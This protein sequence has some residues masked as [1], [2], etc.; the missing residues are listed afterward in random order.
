MERDTARL[1]E[2]QFST[3]EAALP[4]DAFAA[5]I[6]LGGI[7]M[8]IMELDEH[9]T[10]DGKTGLPNYRALKERDEAQQLHVEQDAEAVAS[11]ERRADAPKP[12]VGW[13]VTY[14][15]LD[16]FKLVNDVLG[17]PV[18]DRALWVLAT[19][20]TKS[21]RDEDEVYR[22]G[23]DEFIVFAPVTE[24]PPA[25]YSFGVDMS[26]RMRQNI[27][28]LRGP[29]G[30]EY[31]PRGLELGP[32]ELEA[33]D[34]IDWTIGETFVAGPI[35]HRFAELERADAAMLARKSGQPRV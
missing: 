15:D 17:H 31:L 33:L 24:L 1:F 28:L 26:D 6:A 3:V 25:G 19:A 5:R 12:I 35:I 10:R 21:V 16:N 7:Y 29:Q 13:W 20:M 18:G 14:L 22:D 30:A 34:V 23:G 32:I 8:G 9:A 11:A 2:E 4:E 27:Q